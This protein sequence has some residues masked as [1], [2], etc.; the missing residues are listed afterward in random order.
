MLGSNP[1]PLQLVHWQSDA[2]TTRLDLIR[3]R[4]DLIL[5]MRS[6]CNNCDGHKAEMTGELEGLGSRNDRNGRIG[7]FAAPIHL[8]E[9]V[10][11]SNCIS[12]MGNYMFL[13]HCHSLGYHLLTLLLAD[14]KLFLHAGLIPDVPA[15][16]KLF[17]HRAHHCCS[18][19]IKLFLHRAHPP[20]P[21]D[22]K[23][24]PR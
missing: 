8:C 3:T 20:I 4:L 14:I 6:S 24:V 12:A 1:G 2:L 19:E 21:E 22:I 9:M 7:M 11:C 23:T 17:I 18:P 15:D 5:R 10:S 13:E 16:I